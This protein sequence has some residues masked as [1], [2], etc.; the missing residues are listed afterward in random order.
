MKMNKSFKIIIAAAICALTLGG[1][2]KG[3]D[4]SVVYVLKPLVSDG[5]EN[6][7]M[8]RYITAYAFYADTTQWTVASYD[9]ALAMRITDKESGRTQDEPAAVAEP[10]VEA[11]AAGSCSVSMSLRPAKV[12]LVVVDT[13]LK[14]YGYREQTLPEGLTSTFETVIFYTSRNARRY[15]AGQWMM[16]ND[17][18][19]VPEP[20]PEPEPEPQE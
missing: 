20:E 4:G 11:S 7:P 3:Y 18:Y 16:C 17:F 9:D 10:F 15:K 19:V 14:I 1:C 5:S 13:E 2:L 6:E 12:M 8:E